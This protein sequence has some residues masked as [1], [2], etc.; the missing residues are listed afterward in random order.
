MEQRQLKVKK[1]STCGAVK[2]NSLFQKKVRTRDGLSYDCK[3]CANAKL[4]E[5][6]LKTNDRATKKY[7][8]T[9]KGYVVR[10]YRNMKSRVEGIQKKSV[11]LYEGKEI[12]DK[13][14]F[15]DFMLNSATFHKLFKE[16]VD[17]GFDRKLAP[18]PDRIDSGKGYTKDNIQ[19]VTLSEN[20][21]RVRVGTLD[22]EVVRLVKSM[23]LSG[24]PIS[25]VAI[26]HNLPYHTVHNISVG[27][28]YQWVK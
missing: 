8:K 6:R 7:E 23:L 22:E 13:Q 4:R 3:S 28:S 26:A 14:E 24:S 12:L 2:E 1:C 18:T 19:V 21:S 27:S 16:Y 25:K 11:H 10:M 15:Y 5:R 20:D 9:P 17:S